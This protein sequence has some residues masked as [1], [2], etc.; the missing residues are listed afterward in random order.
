VLAEHARIASKERRAGSPGQT[1]AGGAR[2]AAT[3]VFE[4]ALK[5]FVAPTGAAQIITVKGRFMQDGF[6]HNK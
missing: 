5:R 6:L 1:L 2:S 3:K 4:R